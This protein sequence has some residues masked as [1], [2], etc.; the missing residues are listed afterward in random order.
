MTDP[1]YKWHIFH[2]YPDARRNKKL[3]PVGKHV[4]VRLT[5]SDVCTPHSF[6]VGRLKYHA[7]VKAEPYFVTPGASSIRID[8]GRVTHWCD[9]LPEEVVTGMTKLWEAEYKENTQ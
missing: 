4:L 7:G 5:P 3:P 9:C 1:P 6:V 8:D 2:P